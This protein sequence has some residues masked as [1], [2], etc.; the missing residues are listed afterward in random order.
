MSDSPDDVPR[1]LVFSGLRDSL[2]RGPL[3]A[4]LTTVL[5]A[6]LALIWPVYPLASGIQP[7]VLGLPFSFA[8]VMGWLIVMFVALVLLYRTDQPDTTD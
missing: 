8:W 2:Q 6:G 5:I 3:F 4:F 1:G 7:Y